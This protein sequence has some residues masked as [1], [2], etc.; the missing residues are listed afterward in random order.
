MYIHMYVCK[1]ILQRWSV[2]DIPVTIMT[3][4]SNKPPSEGKLNVKQL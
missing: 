3:N 2:L 1:E 4:Q